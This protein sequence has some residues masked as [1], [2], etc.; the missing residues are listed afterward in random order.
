M[1]DAASEP[2]LDGPAPEARSAERG[3]AKKAMTWTLKKTSG[4]SALFGRHGTTDAYQGDTPITERRSLLCVSKEANLPKPRGL[5]TGEY[6]SPGGANVA[7]WS[8][9]QA[10]AIPDV[11]G[12]S[13]TSEAVADGKCAAAGSIIYGNSGF[14]MAEHHDGTGANPGWGFWGQ[15]YGAIQGIDQEQTVRYW[16]KIKNQ[17]ANP[18]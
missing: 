18:W 2:I 11:L 15:A 13:L 1:V 12:R 4:G 9:R 16:V 14:R 6:K 8:K 5:V 10:F 17:N 7:T 3:A